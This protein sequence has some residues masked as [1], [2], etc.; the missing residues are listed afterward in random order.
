M[1]LRIA[2][3]GAGAALGT[4]LANVVNIVDVGDVVLGGTYAALAGHLDGTVREQLRRR[5]LTAAAA[6]T[7][8]T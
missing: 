8:T 6:S 5:V 7:P 2:L 3:A 1:T 4:A